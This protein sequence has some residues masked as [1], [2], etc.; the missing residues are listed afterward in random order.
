M[1][2]KIIIDREDF[3]I[4]NFNGEIEIL[5]EKVE[6]TIKGH[7]SLKEWIIKNRNL[8]LVVNVDDNATLKY[9]RFGIIGDNNTKIVI[10]QHNNSKLSFRESFI[11][12]ND[13]NLKI[14]NNIF[15]NN[16]NSELIVRCASKNQSKVLVDAS[17]DV[18]KNT[19]D[20]ELNEDLRALELD[21]S[22]ITIIPNMLVKSSEVLASH[23][24]TIGNVSDDDLLYL[25]SKGLSDKKARSLLETGFLISPFSD[26]DFITKIKEFIK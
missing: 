17:L 2:N 19:F 8:N 6:L 23:N 1:Q 5:V 24:V 25:T 18:K 10:N 11:A 7:A 13:T 9:N 12:N 20:N 15:G 26:N 16:N 14:E 22:K 3:I 21:N 4:D